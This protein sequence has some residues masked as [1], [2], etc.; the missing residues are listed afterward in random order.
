MEE[1]IWK[2]ISFMIK[3]QNKISFNVIIPNS[4]KAELSRH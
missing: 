1:E 2:E 4:I 3:Y